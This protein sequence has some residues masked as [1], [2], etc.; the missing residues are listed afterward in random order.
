MQS[1]VANRMAN[2]D[3]GHLGAALAPR[4][5][6]VKAPRLKLPAGRA[7]GHSHVASP[8]PR[9]AAAPVHPHGPELEEA[10]L[11]KA[12]EA[13]NA[14]QSRSDVDLS[15]KAAELLRLAKEQGFL[16]LDDLSEAF[17]N[18]VLSADQLGEIHHALDHLGIEIIDASEVEQP[19]QA[20]AT[21]TVEES[22]QVDNLDDPVRMYLN[23]M[24]RVPLLNREGE[25]AICKRIEEGEQEVRRILY[26]FGFTAKEHIAL[27]E[28]LLAQPPK[29]RFD[30]VILDTK[31]RN[32]EQHL[33]ALRQLV[34]QVRQLD[35]RVDAVFAHWRTA[36]AKPAQDKR[37]KEWKSLDRKLQQTFGRFAYKPRVIEEMVLMAENVHDKFQ[38]SLRALQAAEH[39][40]SAARH[41]NVVASERHQIKALEDFVRMPH[42][43]FL[44]AY[45]Q[46]RHFA[47]KALQAKKEMVEA[48]LRLVVS[49]ARKY[50]NRG[51]SFLDLIQEG[52]LGLM[53]AV[54]KFEYRRGYKFS[55]YAT[56]WIRQAIARA[57]ADQARTVRIPVHMIEVI[58]KVMRA[59][60]Q[61]VQEFG[62]EA[63]PEEIADEMQMPVER[64]QALLKMA[65]QAISLQAPVGEDGD[66]S[67][68]DLIEDKMAENP[69]EVTS[70]HMLKTK[71]SD[72]LATLSDRERKVLELR[73]GLT[74]GYERTL[75]EVGKKY[76]VTR[77]RIR[78]IEAKALRK[79]RHPTRARQLEG[80]LDVEE[81]VA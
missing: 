75:E 69:S 62:R 11:A 38:T 30:R 29:E 79:L 48:N 24:G 52:N 66:A 5:S 77:E 40:G 74:D 15:G 58:N 10:T 76:K 44:S 42:A 13:I 68:G 72:V 16:T 73:F 46:L 56:W 4:T 22:G 31:A 34:K 61:I 21:E 36:A 1:A 53:R 14:L 9:R 12:R 70:H 64:V 23:Q 26:S 81:A 41:K 39:A 49:I 17:P 47:A 3:Q 20:A 55:T 71:L 27:A 25:V 28:K 67:F 60:Q 51:L 8:A 33:R 6:S 65:Q 19:K 54:E 43:E 78:Q 18:D 35:Q 59:Q 80:F 45:G 7:P 37:L 2:E 57:I 50:L 63:T 32:R